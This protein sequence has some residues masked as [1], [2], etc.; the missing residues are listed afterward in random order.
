MKAF[1]QET[2][3]IKRLSNQNVS[4]YD[5][6]FFLLKHLP[7]FVQTTLVALKKIQSSLMS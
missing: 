3:H 7:I 5:V 2:V 6:F 4:D 1:V